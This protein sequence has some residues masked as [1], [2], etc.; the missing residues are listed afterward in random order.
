MR[1]KNIKKTQKQ[2]IKLAKKTHMALEKQCRGNTGKTPIP[3]KKHRWIKNVAMQNVLKRNNGFPRYIDVFAYMVMCRFI[4]SRL[5]DFTN[6]S[7]QRGH[8]EIMTNSNTS[9]IK[10]DG[11]H[12]KS[13]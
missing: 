9:N 11:Q 13:A 7:E 2:N 3:C 8:A 1:H 10:R 5:R 12:Y 6:G 4:F